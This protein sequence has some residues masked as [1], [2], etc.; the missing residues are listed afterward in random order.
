MS[1]Q[2]Y[3]KVLKGRECFHFSVSFFLSCGKLY[4]SFTIL[5]IFSC[6]VALVSYVS[7]IIQGS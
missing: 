5:T 3:F 7:L 2:K 4:M 1:Y 6:T